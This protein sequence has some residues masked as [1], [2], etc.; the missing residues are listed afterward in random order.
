MNNLNERQFE[1]SK[2][3]TFIRTSRG[4]N[5]IYDQ[6]FPFRDIKTF[7]FNISIED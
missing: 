1:A 4:E 6:F 7:S 3:C 5:K 2:N